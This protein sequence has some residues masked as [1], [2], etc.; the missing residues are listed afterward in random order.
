[1]N[2]ILSILLVS[3]LLASC[4]KTIEIKYKDNQS[5]II[6]EGNI[7]NEPGP[8]F[9]KISKSIS[10][11]STE[12][13]PTI[14]DAIVMISDD[15]GNNETLVPQGNGLYK[16]N[17][18]TGTQGRTYTLT[19]KAENETYTSH[20][21]M[22]PLV[23]F[24]SIRSE[25]LY[26][27]GDTEYSVIPIYTDPIPK[28]NNYRFVLSVNNKLVKQHLIQNDEIKNGLTNTLKLEINDNDL[29]LKANDSISLKMQ[30]IDKDVALYYTALVLMA[31]NG[32]GGGTTPNNPPSNISN[33]A[34]GVFSAHTVQLRSKVLY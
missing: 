20:S 17:K 32:P 15:A 31:D 9:V 4:E 5:K 12:T 1:M 14:N 27:L 29:K 18:I 19:V 23:N 6:I 13:A 28:G 8:Y 7:T 33:G 25:T 34:M 22:P 21:T 10:I 16:T 11:S 30:C 26:L 3:A 24:D 2:K